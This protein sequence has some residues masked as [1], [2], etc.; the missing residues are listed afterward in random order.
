M[1]KN[2]ISE[3]VNRNPL[4]LKEALQEELRVRVA[5]ALEEKMQNELSEAIQDNDRLASETADRFDPDKKKLKLKSGI[6]GHL[7]KKDPEI[8]KHLAG[9]YMDD[10]DIVH[11]KTG[12]TMGRIGANTTLADLHAQVKA[13]VEKYHAE[14]ATSSV[15]HPSDTRTIVSASDDHAAKIKA[16]LH[17]KNTKV[18]IMKRKEGNQVY[19]DSTSADHHKAAVS[20]LGSMNESTDKDHVRAGFDYMPD[21]DAKPTKSEI[22][23]HVHEYGGPSIKLTKVRH[24]GPAGGASEVEVHGHVKHVMK[25]LNHHHGENYSLDHAGHK[26]YEEDYA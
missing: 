11:K 2:I 9:A 21:D 16:A 5:A 23:S 8:A 20:K 10:A 1:I 18:R 15:Q 7:K 17:G 25:L 4:G 13:H 14:K 6:I 26:K 12:R 24:N 3:A 22:Q 19:L